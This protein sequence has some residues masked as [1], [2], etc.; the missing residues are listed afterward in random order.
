MLRGERVILRAVERD[1]LPILWAI[2]EDDLDVAVLADGGPVRPSSLTEYQ[3]HYE[4]RLADPPT[5][6]VGF[7][8]DVDGV[9]VGSCLLYWI[10]HFNGRCDLG[11]SIGKEHWGKGYGSD[12]VRT[13]VDYAFT[14]LDLRRVGL[15]CLADDARAV[16]AYRKAGF[17]EEG[18]L[19]GYSIVEGEARDELMMA[20][21]RSGDEPA[22]A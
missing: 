7:T 11:I 1:D 15:R 10:D 16:G 22:G 4:K 3:A 8:I 20:R 6:R 19:R 12:A 13:L 21:Y 18:L 2:L 14:H 5:D 17:V 9:P